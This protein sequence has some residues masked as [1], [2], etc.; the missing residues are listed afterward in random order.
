MISKLFSRSALFALAVFAFGSFAQFGSTALAQTN[1][2]PPLVPSHIA[3][4]NDVLKASG[5]VKMFENALPN[6]VGNLRANVTRT[7]PELARDIEEA[8]KVVTAKSEEM[9]GHGVNDAARFLASRMTE[10]ELKDVN[11][12]LSSPAGKKYVEVLPAFMDDVMPYLQQWHQAAGVTMTAIFNE[13]MAKRG[14][15]L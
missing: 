3:V 4:A 5:L 2:A 15:K 8:L 6:V 14:H 13:E 12:F 10:G 7:R 1:A 11:A 9:M